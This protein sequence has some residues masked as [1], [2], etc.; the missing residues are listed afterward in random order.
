MAIYPWYWHA[1]RGHNPVLTDLG[2]VSNLPPLL[3]LSRSSHCTFPKPAAQIASA[4]RPCATG[5]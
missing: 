4:E 3:K 2:D 1:I 5:V